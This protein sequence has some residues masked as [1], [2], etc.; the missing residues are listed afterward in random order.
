MCR[1]SVK[2]LYEQNWPNFELK[3]KPKCVTGKCMTVLRIVVAILKW[4]PNDLESHER[5]DAFSGSPVPR[6]TCI[7][8][9]KKSIISMSHIYNIGI[10]NANWLLLLLLLLFCC[11]WKST[12]KKHW[13]MFVLSMTTM[14]RLDKGHWNEWY[15]VIEQ[16]ELSKKNIF[17]FRLPQS[18]WCCV[19]IFP[20]R[21]SCFCVKIW[22]I[23][24]LFIE[25]VVGF[26]FI[27]FSSLENNLRGK[28]MIT[29]YYFEW[30]WWNFFL[31]SCTVR[32]ESGH[33]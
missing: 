7:Y 10:Q 16:H 33:K 6:W 29:C 1:I 8:E 19:Y 20:G 25:W 30:K 22:F 31:I 4:I 11:R 3:M 12:F 14:Q 24:H 18:D 32:S 27:S 5:A 13:K 17:I 26:A 15:F 2:V 21:L 28:R 23:A 9:M